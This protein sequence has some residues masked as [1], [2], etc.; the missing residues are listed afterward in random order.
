VSVGSV[1]SRFGEKRSGCK[2][3]T[4]EARCS[5][6]MHTGLSDTGCSLSQHSGC[7]GVRPAWEP[8]RQGA[9]AFG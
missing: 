8:A 3:G 4:R 2:D 7:A 1:G 9:A 6:R 5:P